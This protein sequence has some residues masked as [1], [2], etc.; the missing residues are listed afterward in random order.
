MKEAARTKK[1][2]TQHG[3][4]T[5]GENAISDDGVIKLT[6]EKWKKRCHQ[7]NDTQQIICHNMMGTKRTYFFLTAFNQFGEGG[8]QL[9]R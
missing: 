2:S 8:G 5:G 6:C 3:Y 4:P 9:D 1:S 7:M